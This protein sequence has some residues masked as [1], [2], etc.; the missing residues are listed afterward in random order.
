M[1]RKVIID[2]LKKKNPKVNKTQLEEILDIFCDNIKKALSD[3]KTLEIR[4]FGRFET[5]TLKENFN[6][7]NPSTNE[8]IYVPKRVKVKFKAGKNLKRIINS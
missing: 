8:L 3:G 5:R 4:G 7:R 2:Q 1:S 6:A